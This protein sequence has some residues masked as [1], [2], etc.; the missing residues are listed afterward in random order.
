[1]GHLITNLISYIAILAIILIYVKPF[2]QLGSIF[3]QSSSL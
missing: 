1:M 3:N 2:R